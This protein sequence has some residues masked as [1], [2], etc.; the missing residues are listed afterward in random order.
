MS[1]RFPTQ[2]LNASKTE[3]VWEHRFNGLLK[4]RFY[5][6]NCTRRCYLLSSFVCT[7][8]SQHNNKNEYTNKPTWYERSGAITHRR[9]RR[10]RASPNE[11]RRV[12]PSTRVRRRRRINILFR[13]YFPESEWTVWKTGV[14]RTVRIAFKAQR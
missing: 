3:N 5:R 6:L 12:E 10:A 2:P 9:R 8:Y 11:A 7:F 13:S 1:R 14:F 4:E